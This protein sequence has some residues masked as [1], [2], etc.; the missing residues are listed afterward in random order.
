[1]LAVNNT[2]NTPIQVENV[3]SLVALRLIY[4]NRPNSAK[5][6]NGARISDFAGLC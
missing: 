3:I 4:T 2:L 6:L 1:M 5:V